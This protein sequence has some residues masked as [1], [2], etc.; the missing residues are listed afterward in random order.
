MSVSYKYATIIHSPPGTMGVTRRHICH[1]SL[2][3]FK[4]IFLCHFTQGCVVYTVYVLKRNLSLIVQSQRLL[5][6]PVTRLYQ[7]RWRSTKGKL[8]VQVESLIF[9]WGCS[10]QY[11]MF[12]IFSLKRFDIFNKA[13]YSG[14]RGLRG[15]V[16]SVV[17]SLG[18]FCRNIWNLMRLVLV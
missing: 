7:V 16:R 1:N 9:H 11:F 18:M 12:K 15:G 5:S 17:A 13:K 2:D 10:V 8:C 14:L 3:Y 6:L 4:H